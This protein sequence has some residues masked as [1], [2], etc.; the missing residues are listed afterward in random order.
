ME[1]KK[2][3]K[4]RWIAVAIVLGVVVAA[5]LT[6]VLSSNNTAKAIVA[7]VLAV[8]CFISGRLSKRN[9]ADKQPQE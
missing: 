8:I 9:K 4:G 2:S 3:S 5:I 6:V 7:G 1:P